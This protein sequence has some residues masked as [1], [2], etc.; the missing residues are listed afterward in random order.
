MLTKE[1]A[2]S[3][4]DFSVLKFPVSLKWQNPLEESTCSLSTITSAPQRSAKK[5]T[6]IMLFE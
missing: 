5:K 3:G 4:L 2:V 6:I 1:T